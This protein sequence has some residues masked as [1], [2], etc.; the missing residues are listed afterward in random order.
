MLRCAAVLLY[1]LLAAAMAAQTRF[2]YDTFTGTTGTFLESHTPDTGGTWSRVRGDGIE[3]VSNTVR[4]DRNQ[5]DD[6]YLNDAI[7]PS[8]DYVV[9]ISVT[10]AG[11]NEDNIVELYARASLTLLDGYGVTLD[12]LGNYQITRY[13][14]GTLT[15]GLRA[16]FLDHRRRVGQCRLPSLAGNA[17]CASSPHAVARR[18]LRLLRQRRRRNVSVDR[19]PR[20]GTRRTG[21]KRSVST[22]SVNGTAR[23][24]RAP[25]R[26][27]PERSPLRRSPRSRSA[28]AWCGRKR[29]CTN[30]EAK[31]ARNTSTWP[32]ATR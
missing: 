29:R 30:S 1:S 7:A 21:S 32:R 12:A 27:T 5:S 8:P 13:V 11:N 2:V 16:S 28:K 24:K 14:G 26:S 17:R 22:E 20:A 6:I 10:F 19:P 15:V 4:P 23:S 31:S 25:A 9:G 3:I 18:R